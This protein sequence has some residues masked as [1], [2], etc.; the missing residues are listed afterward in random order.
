M[1]K[2]F[3]S[4]RLLHLEV[5]EILE[6]H[7]QLKNYQSVVNGQKKQIIQMK[8]RLEASQNIQRVTEIENQVV[9]LERTNFEQKRVAEAIY[10]IAQD[11][12]KELSYVQRDTGFE[13]QLANLTKE[14]GKWKEKYKVLTTYKN[15]EEENFKDKFKHMVAMEEER[16]KIKET[17]NLVKYNPHALIDNPG[18]SPDVSSMIRNTMSRAGS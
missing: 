3:N 10:R 7:K 6:R 18:K 4:Q 2:Q 11:Q 9:D 16:S 17:I 15:D 1:Q 12:K 5:P 14:L 13:E 8:T